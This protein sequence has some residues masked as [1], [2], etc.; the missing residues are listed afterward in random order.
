MGPMPLLPASRLRQTS[1]VPMPQT[2]D[3]SD[4]RHDNS[5]IQRKI[6]HLGIRWLE[7]FRDSGIRDTGLILSG[8]AA[9]LV[10]EDA[11]LL[12]HGVS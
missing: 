3:Q 6:L 5:A 7:E 12:R 2:A 10:G 9:P 1:S 8:W 11:A 4:T